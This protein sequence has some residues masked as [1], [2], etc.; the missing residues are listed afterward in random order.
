MLTRS[1][2]EIYFLDY[3][4]GNLTESQ[5]RELVL[6]LE[7]HPDL[8]EEFDSFVNVVLEPDT[9]TSFANK[10]SLKKKENIHSGN[11]RTWLVAYFE[12]DLNLSQIAEVERFLE[13]NPSLKPELE[14]IRRTKISPDHRIVFKNKSVLRKGGKLIG[15]SS[16]AFRALAVAASILLLLVSIYVFRH[17]ESKRS[18]ALWLRLSA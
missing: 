4:E 13:A 8:K 9:L 2:Y 16:P 15:F 6:F 3:H 11:Y 14:I 5:R 17:Q 10:E 1:N 7:Q 18:A 12:K